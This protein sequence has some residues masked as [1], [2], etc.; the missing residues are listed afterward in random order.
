MYTKTPKAVG[1]FRERRYELEV[2]NL[3]SPNV[4]FAF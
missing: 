1:G 2:M 3:A 4:I